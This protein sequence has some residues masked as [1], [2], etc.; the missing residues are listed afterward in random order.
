[1]LKNKDY[2]ILRLLIDLPSYTTKQFKKHSPSCLWAPEAWQTA[3][4]MKE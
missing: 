4:K 2:D 3:Q 1:M